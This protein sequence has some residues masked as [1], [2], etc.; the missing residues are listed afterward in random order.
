MSKVEIAEI[1]ELKE[2]LRKKEAKFQT[3][4]CERIAVMQIPSVK[5]VSKNMAVV[6]FSELMNN[7]LSAETYIASCQ[8]E[9]LI[10]M[11]NKNGIN[12]DETKKVLLG[13]IRDKK[14]KK[15]GEIKPRDIFLHSDIVQQLQSLVEEYFGCDAETAT[16]D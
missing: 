13:A 12:I 10:N 16:T 3:E 6:R 2:N 4:I 14:V 7:N 11:I 15:Y 9:A 1:L 5:N 8:T